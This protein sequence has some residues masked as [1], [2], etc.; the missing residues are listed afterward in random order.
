MYNNTSLQMILKDIYM[1]KGILIH[2]DNRISDVQLTVDFTKSSSEEIMS[3]LELLT[4]SKLIKT[5]LNEY[6]LMKR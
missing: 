1:A 4:G 5:G 2:P 3:T 6:K